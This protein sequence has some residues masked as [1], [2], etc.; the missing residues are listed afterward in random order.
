MVVDEALGMSKYIH[1]VLFV[2][3][4]KERMNVMYNQNSFLLE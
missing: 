2:T 3:L 1:K 4:K